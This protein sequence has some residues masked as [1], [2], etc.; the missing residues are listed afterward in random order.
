MTDYIIR[1]LLEKREKIEEAARMYLPQQSK[2]SRTKTEQDF[3]RREYRDE[4]SLEWRDW[5]DW[6]QWDQVW[7]K[8]NNTDW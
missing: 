2:I 1:K 5:G 7:D 6:S 3:S 8:F 4:D